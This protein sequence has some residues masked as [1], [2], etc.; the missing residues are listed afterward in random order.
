MSTPRERT[1]AAHGS[2]GEP[3]FLTVLIS[4]LQHRTDGPSSHVAGA[5]ARLAQPGAPNADLQSSRAIQ[6]S[7][8]VGRTVLVDATRA[9]LARGG[10]IRGSIG[11]DAPVEDARVDIYGPGGTLVHRQRL[12]AQPAGEL[13]F[14]WDG[15]DAGGAT[16]AAGIYRVEATGLR[17]GR[18]VGLPTTLAAN[19]DSVAIGASGEMTLN[20]DG[21][22]ALS[23]SAV[24]AI[25]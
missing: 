10:V 16:L 4:E 12:G 19:V 24:K 22:G 8:L 25:L 3:D 7:A 5:A 9:R 14:G 18:T 15:R 2:R 6:A 11:I 13:D 21:M 23:I 1:R 17:G 20:V